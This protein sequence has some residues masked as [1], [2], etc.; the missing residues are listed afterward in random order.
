MLSLSL[1]RQ[2]IADVCWDIAV[3]TLQTPERMLI[4]QS[5]KRERRSPNQK[6]PYMQN[7]QTPPHQQVNL[8]CHLIVL[9]AMCL[10][11]LV[12]ASLS[13]YCLLAS[14]WTKSLIKRVLVGV[15]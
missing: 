4:R 5:S 3:L 15:A 12:P 9:R 10:H 14:V 11:V 2:P 13:L 1:G 6:Q 8:L 7:L